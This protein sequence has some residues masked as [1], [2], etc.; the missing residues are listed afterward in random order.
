MEGGDPV[1]GVK[2]TTVLVAVG[3]LGKAIY[4]ASQGDYN[5]MVADIIGFLGT[6]GLAPI[7]AVHNF[8]HP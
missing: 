2:W 4:D 7:P 5:G 8:L 6:V 1:S 3:L